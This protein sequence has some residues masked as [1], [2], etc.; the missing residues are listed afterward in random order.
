MESLT[1]EQD[2]L[3]Q[4]G[5]IKAKYKYLAMVVSNSYKGKKKENN[6]KQS[7][8]RKHDKPKTNDGGLNPPKEKD[9][10]GK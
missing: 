10:K 6:S 9:K 5:T 3:V 4:M 8:K 1:Q 7:N 2:N